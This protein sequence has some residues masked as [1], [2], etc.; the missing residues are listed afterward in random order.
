MPEE[1]SYGE[2]DVVRSRKGWGER[3]VAEDG[4]SRGTLALGFG[5]VVCGF[6]WVVM[7]SVEREWGQRVRRSIRGMAAR[8]VHARLRRVRGGTG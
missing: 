1:I 3:G 8:A 5:I 7:F 6:G 4:A 2:P